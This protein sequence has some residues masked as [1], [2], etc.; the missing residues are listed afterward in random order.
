MNKQ[1]QF[2]VRIEKNNL[3]IQ[4]KRISDIRF[5]LEAM[6]VDSN[7]EIELVKNSRSLSHL[8]N[9]GH[10]SSKFKIRKWNIV[11]TLHVK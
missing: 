8:S 4:V 11:F 10:R 2:M 5:V 9:N 1:T 3:I 6:P 7:L